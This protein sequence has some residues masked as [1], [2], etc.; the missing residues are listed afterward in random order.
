MKKL[1]LISILL[2]CSTSW[3][4]DAQPKSACAIHVEGKFDFKKMIESRGCKKGDPLLLYNESKTRRWHGLLPVRAAAI[5]VCDM[6]LPITDGGGESLQYIMCTYSGEYRNLK[7]DP[8]HSKGW[9][10]F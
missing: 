10:W 4:E 9:I 2:F 5:S 7:L 3:S 1:I 8:E 6:T